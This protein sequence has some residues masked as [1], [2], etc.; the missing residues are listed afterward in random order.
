[1]KT[2]VHPLGCAVILFFCLVAQISSAVTYTL[3]INTNGSGNVSRNPTNSF[4]PQGA[5]VTI[6]A[7]PGSGWV[8]SNWSGDA[9]TNSNPLNVTMDSDKSITANF[10]LIPSFSLVTNVIG[11]GSISLDPSGGTYPSNTTVNVTASA[12]AG[13]F[14]VNWS[15]NASGTNNPTSMTMNGNKS[16]TASFAQSPIIE[17][18][19]Q[20]ILAGLSDTVTFTNHSLG[21]APLFYQWSFND[22]VLLNA[23]NAILT[24]TNIQPQHEGSYSVTVTNAYGSDTKTALLII[25]N[26]CSGSNV[27]S[28]PNESEL[29]AAMA[30]GGV[31]HLCFNGTITLTNTIEVTNNVGLDAR[32]RSVVI[33]G[34]NALRLFRVNSGI[35]FAATNVVF[36]NGRHVGTNGAN[37]VAF[38]SPAQPGGHGEGGAIFNDG[39]SVLLVSSVMTNNTVIGGLGGVNAQPYPD[40]GNG[41]EGRGGA[42][43]NRNGSLKLLNLTIS[44]NLA[45]G[46]DGTYSGNMSRAGNGLGGA[47]YNMG[48]EVVVLGCWLT[49]NI[50]QAP[51]GAATAVA[52]GGALFQQMGVLSLSNSVLS[53]NVA[54]G[55]DSLVINGVGYVPGAAY[56]GAI[57]AATGSV[58]IAKTDLRANLARGGDAYRHS[59]TGTA[60]GGA[61]YSG[62]SIT[63]SDSTFAT[64]RALS[65]GGSSSNTDGRGGSLYNLSVAT[66]E[67]CSFYSNFAHGGSAGNF[68]SPSVNYPGGHGLG[69]SVFNSGQI[70]VTNCTFALN[71][72]QGG[73]AGFPSGVPGSGLGGGIYNSNGVFNAVNTTI[74]SNSVTAGQ[75]YT[76]SGI[77][78]GAN[79]ANTNGAVTLRNSLI[80]SDGINGNTFGT[81]NDGGFNI[82]SDGSANFNSGS[83]FNFTN[84]QLGPLGD[85]GGPTMTMA[86]R[87]NSPAIDFGTGNGAPTVDQRGFS[88]PF[89][90]GTDMGAYEFHSNQTE[91]P[92]LTIWRGTNM[93]SLSFDTFP[94]TEYRLQASETLANWTELEI[95][96]PFATS[97]NITRSS[98]STSP[99]SRFFRLSIP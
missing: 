21:T 22:S 77:A 1:M 23:T 76:Y 3:T 20:N 5:V 49:N 82:S 65:G 32:N 59:G 73:N 28:S 75:G 50:S 53:G 85:F 34:N 45:T 80:A 44:S 57:A 66:F 48:G 33:S 16:V 64:N 96:G 2:I 38:T 86:L 97:T 35:T 46:G 29:R 81:I 25:T 24:L 89:G 26:A 6:T 8:F 31:V 27:V 51:S 67:R 37:A 61:I 90:A 93:I 72:V 62:A 11:Q 42:I 88:R 69:G 87:P 41:G 19:P 12:S 91:R 94:N 63:A 30:L 9:S 17:V 55:G 7:T 4:Y 18:P 99:A 92:R 74:A 39:G 58:S 47:I 78:G 43:F 84:P 83:S 56:G 54:R 15:G 71:S 40:N 52:Q 79:I 36:A 10:H 98:S 14:F 13:W 68:G 95:I 60:L 70:S